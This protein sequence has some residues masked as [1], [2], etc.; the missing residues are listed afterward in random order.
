[1]KLLA[2]NTLIQIENW[3]TYIY[4]IILLKSVD[5]SQLQVE[6]LLDRL[7][8][9]LKLVVSTESI[10]CREFASQF[11]LAIVLYAKNTHTN[12]Y[13]NE[14]ASG[15]CLPVT[16]GRSPAKTYMSGDNSDYRW[17]QIEPKRGN[18]TRQ[19]G[20]NNRLKLHSLKHVV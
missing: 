12:V 1:M 11:G 3:S 17:R 18:A 5:V 20:D 13:L 6:F 9:C 7:G 19:N 8:I 14:A 15:H 2:N 16:V 4:T 10:S